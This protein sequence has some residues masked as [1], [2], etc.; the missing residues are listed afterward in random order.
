MSQMK[1]TARKLLW[2]II[3]IQG[4]GVCYALHT[5]CYR[6]DE[7][8]VNIDIVF[9]NL[10]NAIILIGDPTRVNEALWGRYQNWH[11]KFNILFNI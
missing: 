4:M 10:F 5:N 6:Y 11:F 8:G 2:E 3:Y 1:K 7:K 9:F